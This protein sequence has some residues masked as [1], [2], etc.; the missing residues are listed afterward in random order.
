MLVQP[1]FF[2]RN[3]V[4]TSIKPHLKRWSQAGAVTSVKTD[5]LSRGHREQCAED[6]RSRG[7]RGTLCWFNSGARE[8]GAFLTSA[9]PCMMFLVITR[10]KTTKYV[11]DF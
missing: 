10:D 5:G 8:H 6:E 9:S 3:A 7:A 11:F 1:T 2:R 4:T